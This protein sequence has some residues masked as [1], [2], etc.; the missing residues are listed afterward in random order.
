MYTIGSTDK[1]MVMQIQKVLGIAADGVFGNA[2]KAAVIRYQM[3]HNIVADGVVGRKT[4]EV[5]GIL[6]TD[7]HQKVFRI[8]NEMV[9]EKH[10]LPKDEYIQDIKPI[11]NDYI[12]LHHTA[13]WHNPIAVIDDW[14]K[15]TRGKI[16]TEFVIGGPNFRT[17]DDEF[18]GRIIQAFPEGCQGWHLGSTNSNYMNRHSVGIE[19]C[20]FG[21]L[22]A[23]FKN[24]INIKAHQVQIT[25]LDEAYRGYKNWH[26]YS[27]R[28]LYAAKALL[29]YIA[30]R[31][32]IDL[33]KG[34]VEWI[35]NKGSMK[36]FEYI[37]DAASGKVKGL[38]THVNVRKDKFDLSPQPE[39]IDM[40]LTL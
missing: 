18:D 5:M 3:D 33:H 8:N 23:D 21:Q 37:P 35:H 7:Q 16:A 13:G 26:K 34:L 38:L 1:L 29:L 25:T 2:T 6:D 27:D 28:Q 30:N 39:L 9:V 14:G 11:N 19:I 4:L 17:N 20:N 15:D 36:A 12:F 10:H 32:N 24:Y 40:L 22:T 31:D